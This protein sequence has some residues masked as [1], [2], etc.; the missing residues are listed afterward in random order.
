MDDEG[1]DDEEED[2]E[3][4]VALASERGTARRRAAA[5]FRGWGAHGEVG[6]RVSEW[7]FSILHV[8]ELCGSMRVHV[9]GR[10]HPM[11]PGLRYGMHQYCAPVHHAMVETRV[12][13]AGANSGEARDTGRRGMI[14]I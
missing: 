11:D 9:C 5:G 1:H 6:G 2:G 12:E 4:R 13:R 10:A 7:R 3:A 8:W 14:K